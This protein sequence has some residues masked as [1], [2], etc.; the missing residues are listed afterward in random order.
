MSLAKSELMVSVV[1]FSLGCPIKAPEGSKSL[2]EKS[3]VNLTGEPPFT[4]E[5]LTITK[6]PELRGSVPNVYVRRTT[7]KMSH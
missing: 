7:A 2:L 4:T 1:C 5:N 6:S 3:Q